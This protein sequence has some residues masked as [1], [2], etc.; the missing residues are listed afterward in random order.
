MELEKEN[1]LQFLHVPGIHF[2]LQTLAFR[3]PNTET[4]VLYVKVFHVR[5]LTTSWILF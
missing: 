4:S 1:T 2:M 3:P 5:F